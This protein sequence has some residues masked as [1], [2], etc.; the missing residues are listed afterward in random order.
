[1]VG[2][3]A[4][5]QNILFAVRVPLN[6]ICTPR[7]IPDTFC[8]TNVECTGGATCVLSQ[9]GIVTGPPDGNGE[10]PITIPAS[11]VALNPAVVSGIGTVCVD[12]ASDGVGVH[13]CDGGR[14]DL[15][16]ALSIDHNTSPNGCLG[17][18]NNGMAC[19]SNADCPA[20]TFETC[21]GTCTTGTNVGMPCTSDND[22]PSFPFDCNAN[23]SG[24]ANGLPDDPQCD[25]TFLLPSGSTSFACRE[26][27][28]Q[29]NGGVNDGMICS[30]PADC[31]GA[32]CTLCN[33]AGTHPDVCN[34][35]N[36]GIVA[37]TF[38]S[39][40]IVVSAPLTLTILPGAANNGPDNMPC[41]ADDTPPSPPAPV[42][43]VLGTGTQAVTVFEASN[44]S[45]AKIAPGSICGSQ[46]CGAEIT[47]QGVSCPNLAGGLVSGLKFGG[48]F[49]ALDTTAGDIATTFQFTAQ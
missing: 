8:V 33:S 35:P 40:D 41:T 16:L 3:C 5:V 47:G 4:L 32:D 39:G 28:F 12:F 19:T 49:P 23:N 26:G 45:G 43:V 44:Q 1:V 48:G 36:N 46:P 37:G 20:G 42:Q 30:V 17:G 27:D 14:A 18:P 25:D 13:D 15:N 22:C 6:G 34:S 11:S 31:P 10:A 21:S 24:T 7:T 9:L 29:C 2:S 38:A